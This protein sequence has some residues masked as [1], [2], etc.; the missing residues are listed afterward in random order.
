[1]CIQVIKSIDLR[2]VPCPLSFVRAKLHLEKLESGQVLEVLL[3]A[4]EPIEQVPNSLISDG[5]LVKSID[6]RDRF[7]ALTVQK[8]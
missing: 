2:G 4:G 5:H 1:M 8:A 7:F 6:E 3:D